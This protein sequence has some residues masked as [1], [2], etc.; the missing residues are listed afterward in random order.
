MPLACAQFPEMSF[1]VVHT[2]MA[3][4]EETV[5]LAMTQPN[6]FFNL[7]TSFATIGRQPRRFAEFIGALL[8]YGAA[9]RLLYA[10]GMSLVHP[11]H[12][13]RAFMEFE[14]PADLVR[15]RG[16][17]EMT[18]DIRRL[19]LGENFLRMHGIDSA[20]LRSAIADDEV[21]QRQAKGLEPAWSNVRARASIVA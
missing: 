17:P 19:I 9:D 10:S 12:S 15:G 16:Y 20:E 11:L 7:E 3:F 13:L 1:E 18:D 2:G 8:S 4:V 5:F 21:S 6:C 14:M